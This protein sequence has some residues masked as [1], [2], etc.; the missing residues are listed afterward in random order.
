METENLLRSIGLTKYE[1]LAYLAL[2]EEGVSDAGTICRRAN[3]PIGKVYETLETLKNKRLIE[4]Q[5]TRPKKYLAKKPK[6]A[7][8]NLYDQKKEDN[9]RQLREFKEVVRR[10]EREVKVSDNP[11]KMQSIFWTMVTGGEDVVKS[12]NSLFDECDEEICFVIPKSVKNK[13]CEF[14]SI[15]PRIVKYAKKAI[16]RNVKIKLIDPGSNLIKLIQEAVNQE[17]D[18]EHLPKMQGLVEIKRLETEHHFFIIDNAITVL[19]IKDPLKDLNGI[20]AMVKNYDL[21]FAGRL[22]EKFNELWEKAESVE[23]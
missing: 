8:G 21:V 3:I 20:F 6:H 10:I 11:V 15:M 4:I 23:I 9:E 16:K 7:F 13:N 12:I 5:N 17:R 2:L 1:A 18:N 19:L 14:D 22:K